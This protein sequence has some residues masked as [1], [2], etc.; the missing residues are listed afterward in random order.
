V[1]TAGVVATPDDEVEDDDDDDE[2]ADFG[3]VAISTNS[4]V[5]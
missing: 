4:S 2:L 1:G 3:F 5:R